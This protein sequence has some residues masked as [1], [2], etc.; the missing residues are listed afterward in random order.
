[1][2]HRRQIGNFSLRTGMLLTT[3][4][5]LVVGWHYRGVRRQQA[6]IAAV[7]QFGGSVTYDYERAAHDE[8]RRSAVVKMQSCGWTLQ[9]RPEHSTLMQRSLI[10]QDSLFSKCS[11]SAR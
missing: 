10:L 5:V 6:A 3:I 8:G 4:F 9:A 7:K 2:K 1:M 11:V